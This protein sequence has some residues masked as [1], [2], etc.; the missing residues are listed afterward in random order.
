MK[1]KVHAK[2]A[3]SAKAKRSD[4]LGGHPPAD[5]LVCRRAQF[6]STEGAAHNSLGWSKAEPQVIGVEVTEAL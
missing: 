3:K 4:D 1:N 2:H 5:S 6:R